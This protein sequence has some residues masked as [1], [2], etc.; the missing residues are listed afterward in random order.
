MNCRRGSPA[1]FYSP[2]PPFTPSTCPSDDQRAVYLRAADAYCES[3]AARVVAECSGV[4]C[5]SKPGRRRWRPASPWSSHGL[6]GEEEAEDE[7]R[8]AGRFRHLH[9]QSFAS[10]RGAAPPRASTRPAP[11]PDLDLS[12]ICSPRGG[13][14]E[15]R[16]CSGAWTDRT[17][18]LSHVSIDRARLLARRCVRTGC[19]NA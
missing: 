5:F 14:A 8:G 9:S 11:F 13:G 15:E 12:P 6:P 1:R 7:G 10:S 2:S 16:F 17:F 18:D 4:R 3:I 19:V